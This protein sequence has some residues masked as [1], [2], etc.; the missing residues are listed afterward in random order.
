MQIK[1]Q[2]IAGN[3]KMNK[4]ASETVIF[5][6]Q[7]KPLVSD[8]SCTVIVCVPFT[9]IVSAVS[10]AKGSNIKIGSQN[11]SWADSGAYTGEIS[12]A[13]LT[14]AGAEYVIIGHSERRQ[15][16][17]ETNSTV[18]A[19]TKAALKYNLKPIVC[20]GEL[21]EHR[22][23]SLTEMILSMQIEEGFNGIT[24]EQMGN[25]IVA[26]EPVWAIGTGVVA[27]NEQAEET[28]KYCRKVFAQMYNDTVANSLVIQY[29]G[30]MNDTNAQALLS[31]PNIDGGLIGGASLIESKF[32]A[33]IAASKQKSK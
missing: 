4:L 27:T 14:E 25:I 21:L 33:I 16:F 9:D 2:V 23:Q 31:M 10:A 11:I 18:L 30:S 1:K 6:N 20:I 15:Y 12:G 7:L 8:A 17:G 5:I 19:R 32:A 24:A 13:M 29:G 3:W 22:Q 26:Y 28:I